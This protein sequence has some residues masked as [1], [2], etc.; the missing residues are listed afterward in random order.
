MTQDKDKYPAER[1]M[2]CYLTISNIIL[3]IVRQLEFSNNLT[4]SGMRIREL[5]GYCQ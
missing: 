2:I 1:R 3:L 4:F 5:A